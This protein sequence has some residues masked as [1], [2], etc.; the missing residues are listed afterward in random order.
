MRAHKINAKMNQAI[1]EERTNP[2]EYG[3]GIRK[4]SKSTK[5]KIPKKKRLL[6]DIS[7]MRKRI[8]LR[9]TVGVAMVVYI[10]DVRI[11][12]AISGLNKLNRTLIEHYV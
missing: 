10:I 1:F 12:I 3:H 11:N 8:K 7:P 6:L 9:V 2:N 5:V 4:N